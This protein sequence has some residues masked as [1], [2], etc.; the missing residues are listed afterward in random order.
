[1]KLRSIHLKGF[2]TFGTT[3]RLELSPG[4]TAIVGPNG[5]GKSNLADAVAWV[6]GEQALSA[7]RIRRFTDLIHQP[8]NG[9][10]AP[11][12]VEVQISLEDSEDILPLEGHDFDINRVGYRDGASEY[13]LNGHRTRLTRIREVF[14][15]FG[16]A[17]RSFSLIRQGHCEQFL[18][19]SP[20]QRRRIVEEAAGALGLIHK[21]QAAERRLARISDH[22]APVR[23]ELRELKLSLAYLERQ[24]RQ[25]ERRKQLL[26]ELRTAMAGFYGPAFQAVTAEL[27]HV[28]QMLAEVQCKQE[29]AEASFQKQRQAASQLQ[30]QAQL[31]DKQWETAQQ[32]L[33]QAEE[34]YRDLLSQTQVLI[35]RERNLR[36]L[37]HQNHNR[38]QAEQDALTT[39]EADLQQHRRVRAALEDQTWQLEQDL[40]R[41]EQ[42]AARQQETRDQHQQARVRI[43][44]ALKA[45]ATTQSD[46]QNEQAMLLWQQQ[47]EEAT[48]QRQE[49]ELR[50]AQAEQL[51]IEN[52]LAREQAELERCTRQKARLDHQLAALLAAV[53]ETGKALQGQHEAMSE[54]GTQQSRCQA[55]RDYL[56]EM[57]QQSTVPFAHVPGMERT[58]GQLAALLHVEPVHQASVAACLGDWQFSY[59]FRT[60]AEAL[61]VWQGAQEAG[62]TTDL[63]LAVLEAVPHSALSESPEAELM[64]APHAVTGPGEVHALVGHLLAQSAIAQD[65]Q[66]AMAHFSSDPGEELSCIATLQGDLIA[67]PG[68]VKIRG[69]G[70]SRNSLLNV[71]HEMRE[72]DAELQD[73]SG[74]Q[75]KGQVQVQEVAVQLASL[76]G[77]AGNVR[78]ALQE[79]VLEA[80]RKG[81]QL[82]LAQARHE[83]LGQAIADGEA[84]QGARSETVRKRT[85]R[86]IEIQEALAQMGP[87]TVARQHALEEC[88]KALQRGGQAERTTLAKL[89]ER[90]SARLRAREAAKIQEAQAVQRCNDLEASRQQL[91]AEATALAQDWTQLQETQKVTARSLTA[92]ELQVHTWRAKLSP[93]ALAKQQWDA[94]RTAQTEAWVQDRE[95]HRTLETRSH[96]LALRQ[97]ETTERHN[98]LHRTLLQDAE[99]LADGPVTDAEA[100]ALLQSLKP[101]ATDPP[102]HTDEPELARLRRRIHRCGQ[103]NPDLY[104]RFQTEQDRYRLLETQISDLD[105]AEADLRK[106]ILQL[107]QELDTITQQAFAEINRS[108]GEYFGRFFPGGKGW[109]ELQQVGDE[110]EPGMELHVHLQGQRPQS[111]AALSGGERAMTAIAFLYA[112]L[113]FNQPPFCVLDEIDAALDEANVGRI[114]SS[115]RAL[116]RHTQFILITHN[117]RM[118][119]Y[120]DSIFG[121]TKNAEGISQLLSMELHNARFR[122]A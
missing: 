115:L 91:Q 61:Q 11:N 40:D 69:T 78:A 102:C 1:M 76:E 8:V 6:L 67:V 105:A 90:H 49:A 39:A 106:V 86:L 44:A 74:R 4:L 62:I 99:L 38:Q 15:P 3:T 118:L 95:N 79:I 23:Q 75:E 114:G 88:L 31:L 58:L 36:R 80:Q 46:L 64:P 33:S 14:A 77:D 35:E 52:S 85:V 10:T 56:T 73:L 113:K 55:R 104:Q 66:D 18:T 117:Q 13:R 28:S 63:R 83:S 16:M 29:A 101:S 59:V 107:E 53:A 27:A 94:K 30:G 7:L 5:S 25:F 109:L 60:W 54:L 72:L 12:L 43:E 112:L 96:Q 82:K 32:G 116:T 71:A 108:F 93:L 26:A 21:K 89:Q 17:K 120:A 34:Q 68:L 84:A 98:W 92:A 9:L 20:A 48:V 2:K 87:R 103:V 22:L 45:D 81:H 51:Q 42:E 121:V 47:Q 19:V 111:I 122:V 24:A 119:E 100:E 37:R 70:S 110:P 50:Q 41:L 65:V 97:A 57:S